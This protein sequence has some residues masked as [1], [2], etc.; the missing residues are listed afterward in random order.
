[1]VADFEYK[2]NYKFYDLVKIISV[3]RS[4][5]G[6]PWDAEQTHESIRKNLIEETYEL[7]EAINMADPDMMKEELGDLMMQVVFHAGISADK[8]GF[9]IDDVADEVCKKLIVRHPH[10]FS[11]VKVSGVGDVLNNWDK[12]KQKTKGQKS[13]SETMLSVPRELPALMRSSKVQKRAAGVGFDWPDAWDAFE[14]L[15]E[16]VSELKNA[17]EADNNDSIVDELGD[18]IFSAVNVARLKGLDAEEVLTAATEKFI[19]RF[20]KVENLAKARGLDIKEQGLDVLDSLWDEVK[21]F[22]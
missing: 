6:C 20:T 13:I 9:D 17:L 14:K 18:V 8:G 3:L 21:S 10:V 2:E 7:V 16:E 15:E 11:D 5:G 19:D 12:I 1:M 4:P 22:E